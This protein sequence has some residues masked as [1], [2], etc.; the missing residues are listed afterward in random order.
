MEEMIYSFFLSHGWKLTL[1]ALS[2]IFILGILKVFNLFGK[3]EKSKRKYI[4]AAISTGFSIAASGIYLAATGIFAWSTFGMLSIG[5]FSVNQAAYAVYET[6]G[7]RALFRKIGNFFIN[8]FT[9]TKKVDDGVI[10]DLADT[11]EQNNPE[12]TKQETK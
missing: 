11:T 9:K 2:G 4:Y 10:D 3:L 6:Y 8:V 12:E 5:I 1:I 7:I